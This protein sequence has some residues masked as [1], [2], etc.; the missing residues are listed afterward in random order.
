M[1]EAEATVKTIDL[2]G[3]GASAPTEEIVGQGLEASKPFIRQLCQAQ[4]ELAKVAAKPTAEFPV[5]LEYQSDA[6]EAVAKKV[7]DETAK[8][9]TIVSKADREEKL[10]AIQASVLEELA[11]E[12]EG[13]EKELKAAFKSL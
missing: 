3:S 1:V 11:T 7:K 9:L 12:F 5:F 4:I 13:R 6:A 8:A 10:D 2:I